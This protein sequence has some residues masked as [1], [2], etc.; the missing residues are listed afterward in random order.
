MGPVFSLLLAAMGTGTLIACVFCIL[1]FRYSTRL[2]LGWA[3]TFAG[4][5]ALVF[6]LAV[7]AATLVIGVG[8]TLQSAFTVG[9][10][11]AWLS[12]A[13]F[14]G[15]IAAVRYAPRLAMHL[16]SKAPTIPPQSQ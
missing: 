8:P 1:R 4:G 16:W 3:V 13:S 9:L 11:F 2:A 12:S 7:F 14:V 6:V 10:Y 5:A 15:G